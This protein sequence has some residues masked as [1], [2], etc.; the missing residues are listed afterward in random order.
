[1]TGGNDRTPQALGAATTSRGGLGDRGAV[2][3]EFALVFPVL[4]LMFVGVFSVGAV[5]IQ[6]MQLTYVVQG[7]AQV[8]AEAKTPAP[9]PGVAWAHPLLPSVTFSGNLADCGVQITG[10]WPVSFGVFP[11]LMLSQTACW[12]ILPPPPTTPP[13]QNQ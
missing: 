13:I 7:A 11:T 10:Q 8:G 12:P 1:M 3:V 6:E 5:M 4:L 2:A 9:G